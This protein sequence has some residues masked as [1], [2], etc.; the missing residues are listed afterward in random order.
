MYSGKAS[1]HLPD[2]NSNQGEKQTSQS[3]VLLWHESQ[4]AKQI[5]IF[6]DRPVCVITGEDIISSCFGRAS[7]QWL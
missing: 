4:S 7:A 1:S 2:L 5:D 6:Y 3:P